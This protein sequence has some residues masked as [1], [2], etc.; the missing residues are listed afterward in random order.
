MKI[1]KKIKT[2]K[3]KPTLEK[4]K[5][6]TLKP[7]IKK[8]SLKKPAP[9]KTIATKK[10]IKK[11]N[12]K[13]TTKH[14][15]DFADVVKKMPKGWKITQGT[16]TQPKGTV[17]IDNGESFFNGKRKQKLLI[18]DKKTFNENIKKPSSFYKIKPVEKKVVKAVSKPSR[19]K[20][21]K[22]KKTET[23]KTKNTVST[24]PK[25]R[26]GEVASIN[27][28][29][30]SGHK[31]SI[32]KV[33]KTGEISAFTLTHSKYTHGR[34]NIPLVVNPQKNDKRKAYVVKKP[35]KVAEK[36]IGKHH[37]NV[38]IKNS[39]DKSIMRKLRTTA[40]KNNKKKSG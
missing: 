25:I 35:H 24:K 1:I 10:A 2:T 8:Q 18:V 39:T 17:W 38:R 29:R 19:S 14:G 9:K 3:K 40:K 20:T 37:P 32:A 28:K 22:Y 11:L 5:K 15:A 13:I 23:T 21:V 16:T 36:H 27:T 26:A 34:K 7:T 33:K 6:T 4:K 12:T 30:A 31:G